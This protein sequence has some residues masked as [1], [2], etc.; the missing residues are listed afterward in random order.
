MKKNLENKRVFLKEG[1]SIKEE[2]KKNKIED[3]KI[4][5]IKEIVFK[6]KRKVN[7]DNVKDY[8]IRYVGKT[9]LIKETDEVIHIGSRFLDEYTGSESRKGLM[10]ANA[11]AKANAATIIPELISKATNPVFEENN[12]EKHKKDAKYGWYRYDIHFAVPV[13]ENDILVRYN[14]YKARLLINHAENGNKY[15]YDILAIKKETSRPHQ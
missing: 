11:K 4:V 6:G 13:Y 2:A 14:L 15:L 9:Y 7:W 8:L 10:G 1:E 3:S 12:K 5:Y